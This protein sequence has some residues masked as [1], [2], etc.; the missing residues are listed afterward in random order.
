MCSGSSQAF[1]WRELQCTSGI[2]LESLSSF[3]I[4]PGA[5]L[6]HVY[7]LLPNDLGVNW[8]GR[9]VSQFLPLPRLASMALER[10]YGG[11]RPVATECD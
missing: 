3:R 2:W 9:S 10:S 8:T 6:P 4:K 5:F 7:W 11:K 1:S